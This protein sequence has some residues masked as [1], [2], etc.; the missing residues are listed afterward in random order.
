MRRLHWAIQR[1]AGRVVTRLGLRTRVHP[2]DWDDVP[3]S[4]VEAV[5][6]ITPAPLLLVHGDRDPYF[7]LD[8]PLSLAAAADPARTT[9][10]IEH[11]FGHAENAAEPELLNRVGGWVTTALRA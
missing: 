1:P 10:W 5:P 6:R 4:P 3:R 2:R 8:H 7:P 9:L 11:G